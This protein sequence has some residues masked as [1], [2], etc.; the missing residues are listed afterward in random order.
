MS[1]ELFHQLG[2]KKAELLVE[3]A[4]LQAEYDELRKA[5]NELAEALKPVVARLKEARIPLAEIDKRRA[6]ISRDLGGKTGAPE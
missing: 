5:Q 4:P 2:R 1:K 6:A 3:M